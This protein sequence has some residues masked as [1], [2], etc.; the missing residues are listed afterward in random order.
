MED[1]GC[2]DGIKIIWHQVKGLPFLAVTA[3]QDDHLSINISKFQ[4]HLVA[5]YCT[6]LL[7]DFS[8]PTSLIKIEQI[9]TAF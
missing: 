8:P 4:D 9:R 2:T 3:A 5:A 7:K 1:N 6:L